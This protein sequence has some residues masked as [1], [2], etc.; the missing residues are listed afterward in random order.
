MSSSFRM[1]GSGGIAAIRESF[2]SQARTTR[3]ESAF[4]S[5]F[6]KGLTVDEH[7]SCW[8]TPLGDGWYIQAFRGVRKH[9]DTCPEEVP[10]A[11]DLNGVRIRNVAAV[12]GLDVG[13]TIC[14]STGPN[15]CAFCPNRRVVPHR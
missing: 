10:A 2:E 11:C 15:G 4:P 8:Q 1:S 7:S 9:N 13:E 14:G 6:G 12:G 3:E 5:S